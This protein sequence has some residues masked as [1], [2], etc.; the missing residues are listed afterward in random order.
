[1]DLKTYK[2][3]KKSFKEIFDNALCEMN[4]AFDNIMKEEKKKKQEK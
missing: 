2:Q 3:I 4:R 1:M